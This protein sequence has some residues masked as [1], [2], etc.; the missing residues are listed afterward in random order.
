[1]EFARALATFL[2]LGGAVHAQVTQAVSVSK[3][4]MIG[5]G[6][7]GG[8][9]ISL[10]G[11]YVAFH[12]EANALVSA[13]TNGV[14]D[15]FVRDIWDGTIVRAS[16]GPGGIEGDGPAGEFTSMSEDGHFVAFDSFATNLVSGD[17]NAAEDVFVYDRVG[18][19]AECVSVA[20]GGVPGPGASFAPSISGDGRFVAFY[21]ESSGLV[22]GDTNGCGDVFV[23]DRVNG[24]TERVSVSSAGVEGDAASGQDRPSISGDGRFVAF[25]SLATNLAPGVPDGHLHVYVRDRL[26]GTTERVSVSSAGIQDDGA[27]SAPSISYDGLEVAFMSDATNLVAGDTNGITDVFVRDLSAGTTVRVSVDSSGLQGDG[28]SAFPSVSGDGRAGDWIVAFES[29]ATNLVPGDTNG[30]EDVFVHDLSTG[31]T[32]RASVHTNGTQGNGDSRGAS[33]SPTG[34]YVTFHSLA[35]NLVPGITTS[36]EIYLRYREWRQ[37]ATFWCFPGTEGLIACPCANP[38]SGSG[39]GCNNSAGTGGAILSVIGGS[40]LSSDSVVISTQGEK[41]TAL[42]VLFKSI[43]GDGSPGWVYGQGVRCTGAP[44]AR[45]YTKVASAGSI[46]VPDYGAGDLSISER[47]AASGYPISPGLSQRY[48][49]VYRDGIVLG[50]CPASSTF[51]TTPEATV[52][53]SP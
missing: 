33:I 51:N 27:S 28:A 52:F 17:T 26:L 1:M 6:H 21:S 5:H 11:R 42:S 35:T 38:P 3:N 41:P 23:R 44:L 14:A 47:S 37:T 32:V 7:C 10:N 53:W 34:A 15:V 9:S 31:T 29:S 46:S 8:N 50:G 39:R 18:G 48:F 40:F 4:G 25:S 16:V 20:S 22:A 24:T 2:V 12:S 45:L 30:V 49:V 43:W 13:D 36:D 19:T